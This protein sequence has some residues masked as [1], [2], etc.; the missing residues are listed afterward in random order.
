MSTMA[1]D[2]RNSGHRWVTAAELAPGDQVHLDGQPG[3]VVRV[4]ASCEDVMVELWSRGDF[5]H[6][7]HFLEPGQLVETA[8]RR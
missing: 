8:A 1:Y 6:R 4:F 2:V 5:E 3:L 7:A